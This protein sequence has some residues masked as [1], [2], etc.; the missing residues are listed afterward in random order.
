MIEQALYEH[1]KKQQELAEYLAVYDDNPAVF[2]QEAPAD[3]DE[4][5]EYGKQYGRVV[6]S[7]DLQGDPERTMGGTLVVDISCKES[8]QLP[9]EIEPVVRKLIHGY[10]FSSGTFAAAAQWKNSSYFTE[11]TNDVIGCTVSFALL[12]FPV[13][14]TDSPDVTSRINEWTASRFPLLHVINHDKLPAAAWKPEGNE[15]AVYWRLVQDTPAGWIPDTCQ[16]IWRTASLRCHIF[17]ETNS[18]AATVARGITTRLYAEKRLLKDGETPIMVNR[19]NSVGLGEDPLRT[20]Q[21]SVEATYAIVVRYG[22]EDVFQNL[23]RTQE[24]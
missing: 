12:A 11:P 1:L 3:N 8:E 5:W 24:E 19:R 7:V 16:T 4:L 9:E 18:I 13:M 23:N 21:V 15:S 6:F 2:N 14:T 17:S 10:F 20:G 22:T